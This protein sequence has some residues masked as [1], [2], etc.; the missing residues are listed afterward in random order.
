MPDYDYGNARLHAMKSRLLNRRELDALVGAGSLQ[1]LIAMLAKTTYQKSIESAMARF[2]DMDSIEDALRNNLEN[3]VGK[4]SGFYT[5]DAR[6]MVNLILR[7]YDIQNLIAILRGLSNQ[8]P[9]SEIVKSLL[10]IGELKFNLLHQLAMLHNPREAIDTLASMGQP[11]ARPLIALRAEHPGVKQF[12]FEVA[13]EQ[14][15][16]RDAL[17]NLRGEDKLEEG[18][19]NALALDADLANVMTALRFARDPAELDR[20]HD[21]FGDKR[22][23]RFFVGPG[24]ISF[25]LLSDACN[26]G[27]VA[28][29]IE[30]LSGTALAPALRLGLK[31][32]GQSQ[33]LSDIEKPLKRHR[34]EWAAKQL[35]KD[36]LGIGVA[37]GYIA[38]KINEVANI[39]WIAQ[40][41][42]LGL[43][44]EEIKSELE[45]CP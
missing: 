35:I 15:Y 41:T 28:G 23:T 30:T 33:R 4:I 10:P 34:L 44:T 27:N 26:R 19:Y 45:I 6:E 22:V 11:F 16:Y 37:L 36:S 9:A 18:L 7:N 14:W 40:G 20:L 13:L 39:R 42:N 24:H 12:E 31:R 2:S 25:N 17:H 43:A 38:I 3:T 1:G 32:Y 8:V 29:A 21:L 5:E